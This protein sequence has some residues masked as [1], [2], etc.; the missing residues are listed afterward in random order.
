MVERPCA[1]V[2]QERG[3]VPVINA[4]NAVFLVTTDSAVDDTH[5]YVGRGADKGDVHRAAE[6]D[7]WHRSRQPRGERGFLSGGEIDARDPTHGAFRN[8]ERSIGADGA[9][10]RSHQPRS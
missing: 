9:A 1:E 3:V 8:V 4:V 2:H 10:D 6:T 7:A 5:Q